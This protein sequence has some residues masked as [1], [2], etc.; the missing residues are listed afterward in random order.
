LFACRDR[1]GVGRFPDPAEDDVA[2]IWR[3][4]TGRAPDRPEP[5]YSVVVGGSVGGDMLVG[6]NI[7]LTHVHEAPAE[8]PVRIRVVD[9]RPA[10]AV[11]LQD[12][13][14]FAALTAPVPVG[15]PAVRVLAG[16]RG[17]GKSQLAAQYSRLRDDEGWEVVVWIPAESEAAIIGGWARLAAQL[18]PDVVGGDLASA[19]S[20]AITWISAQPGR[21][22]IVYDNA[23]DP[24]EVT[25]LR[26]TG[27]RVEV[28]IT[29][30]HRDFRSLGEMID[31][32]VFGIDQAAAYLA[33]RTRLSDPDGAAALADDLG[34]LPLALAQ[35]GA[36]IGADRRYRSYEAYRAKLARVDVDAMMP[37]TPGDPYPRG[38]AEA[39]LLAVGELDT[40]PR[41]VLDVLALLS[42]DGVD[43][44]LLAVLTPGSDTVE[45]WLQDLVDRSLVSRSDSGD[46]LIV[47]RMIQRVLRD[48]ARRTDRFQQVM[49]MAIKVLAANTSYDVDKQWPQRLRFRDLGN[50]MLT[51]QETIIATLGQQHGLDNVILI[52]LAA[53]LAWLAW[54]LGEVGDAVAAVA[55][56]ERA[57]AEYEFL[58]DEGDERLITTRSNL[59][60]AYQ[61]AG[62]LD[63]AIALIEQVLVEF[64][65]ADGMDRPEIVVFQLNLGVAYQAAGR[66]DDAIVVFESALIHAERLLEPDHRYTLQVLMNLGSA[67][68]ANDEPERAVEIAEDG[69][70]RIAR[71]LGDQH[72]DTLN[73]RTHLAHFYR[74]AGRLDE[75][76][77]LNEANVEDLLA[78]VGQENIR[79]LAAQNN[80]ASTYQEAGRYDEAISILDANLTSRLDVLGPEHPGTMLAGNNLAYAYQQAGYL[81]FAI[82][83]YREVLEDAERLLGDGHPTTV[84]LI[85]NLTAAL[86]EKAEI[87]ESDD[88]AGETEP[89]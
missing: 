78:A 54:H 82:Q 15:V 8:K 86:E 32:D 58:L 81:D 53:H 67:L 40:A 51:L 29:T 16:H 17:V 19:A 88:G 42:P 1:G 61:A 72:P 45:D 20:T 84:R 25:R 14:E 62:R 35:A 23:V 63:D 74:H 48:T 34:C 18:D 2:S 11:D 68:D 31:L 70:A 24:D 56:G 79:T 59:A 71:T 76:I 37:R 87:P 36:L 5:A 41:Q 50:Q 69:V 4:L 9:A 46:E 26:P 44:S 28:L 65:E 60:N 85:E 30:N 47:H 83:M 27:D 3:R 75:A 13:P 77:A 6:S 22:L 49:I 52:E 80:L 38:L 7:T 55:V 12:R 89:E 43:G 64:V 21:A 33:A 57:L 73:A 39:T 66:I 10:A